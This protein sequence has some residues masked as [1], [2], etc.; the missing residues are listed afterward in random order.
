MMQ[1]WKSR[2]YEIDPAVRPGHDSQQRAAT[3][4]QSRGAEQFEMKVS[5]PPCAPTSNAKHKINHWRVNSLEMSTSHR[6][7][8]QAERV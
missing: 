2:R 6:T 8:R 3:C 1:A 5:P 4:P 7:P